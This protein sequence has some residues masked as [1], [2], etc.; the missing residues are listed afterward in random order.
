MAKVREFDSEGV[1]LTMGFVS[2]AGCLAV[3]PVGEQLGMIIMS[4][5][6]V[7]NKATYEELHRELLPVHLNAEML[8]RATAKAV[9]QAEPDT[10]GGCRSRPTTSTATTPSTCSRTRWATGHG[11]EMLDQAWPPFQ[12]PSY[13]DYITQVADDDAQ[14]VLSFL[15]A[16]D[17]LNM[18]KQQKPFGLLDGRVVRHQGMDLDVL[19]PM[20]ASGDLPEVWNGIGYHVDAFDSPT[21]DEFIAAFQEKYDIDPTYYPGCGYM[22]VLAYAA[23]IEKAGDTEVEASEDGTGGPGVRLA[24]GQH[25]DQAR[26]PPGRVRG[27]RRHQGG[28]H[29]GRRVRGRRIHPRARRR[30]HQPADT[31]RAEP[32]R[33]RELRVG[34]L[35]GRCGPRLRRSSPRPEYDHTAAPTVTV[36]AGVPGRD[37]TWRRA[38]VTEGARMFLR[39][40]WY[41]VGWSAD[42]GPDCFETRTVLGEDLLVFRLANGELRVLDDRCSHRAAPLSCGRREADGVRCLYHGLR[43]DSEGA[44]V[45][46]PGQD[47]VPGRLAVRRYPVVEREGWVLVWMGPSADVDESLIPPVVGPAS[48]EWDVGCGQ[49]DIEAHHALMSDNLCDFSHLAFVHVASFGGGDEASSRVWAASQPRI[50][51]LERGIRVSRWQTGVPSGRLTEHVGV[52]ATDRFQTYDYLAPGVLLMLSASY[53]VGTAAACGHA[54]DVPD[55]EPLHANFT[56]Q[57]LTPI[58]ERHTRYH[59]SWG[60]SARERRPFMIDAMVKLATMAFAEDKAIIEAQQRVLDRHP[61]AEMHPIVHD[62]GPNMMRA[63]MD[64][65]VAE[66]AKAAD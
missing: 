49:M 39:K 38:V 53:P 44:C 18:L 65:L 47:R 51:P 64:R 13:T 9:Q 58:D 60:P 31:R 35:A 7:T 36:V 37:G 10:R 34:P 30:G 23:A 42:F 24:D 52:A 27:H 33:R 16:G 28:A 45:E 66:E 62:R 57:T 22:G 1:D 26:G 15:Y 48:T 12:S 14:G 63:V 46:I 40:C 2:S 54:H 11:F 25:H 32:L 56:S 61:D 55:V 59:F 17:M 20:A 6:C 50:D 29:R 4:F 43:F 21:N 5:A 19:E 3:A 41:A 8:T